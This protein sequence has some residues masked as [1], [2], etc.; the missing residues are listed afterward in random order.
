LP[1]SITKKHDATLP[2][3]GEYNNYFAVASEMKT[4]NEAMAF[5]SCTCNCVDFLYQPATPVT[6]I[7]ACNNKKGQY[8]LPHA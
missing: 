6:T 1:H 7:A 4:P 3:M 5:P 8:Y 2:Y